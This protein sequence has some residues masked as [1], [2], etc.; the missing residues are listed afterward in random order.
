M[1]QLSQRSKAIDDLRLSAGFS[2]QLAADQHAADFA[3]AGT[4]LVQLGIA[5][6]AARIMAAAIHPIVAGDQVCTA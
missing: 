2:K 5:P 1:H 6:Q 3:G 4:N